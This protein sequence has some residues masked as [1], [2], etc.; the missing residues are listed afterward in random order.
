VFEKSILWANPK[1]FFLETDLKGDFV[2][3]KICFEVILEN[4]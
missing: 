2:G 3:G 1:G 4:L